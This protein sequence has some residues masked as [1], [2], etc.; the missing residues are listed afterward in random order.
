VRTIEEMLHDLVVEPHRTECLEFIKTYKGLFDTSKGSAIKHQA[1]PGGYRDH[2][3]EVMRICLV[4]YQA[5]NGSVRTPPFTLSHALVGCFL[6]D[7]EKLWKHAIDPEH[8]QDIDKNDLL[9]GHFTMDADL[10]NS[11]KYAHGEGDDYHPTKLV[12][13]PLAAFVHHCDN[14]SARIWPGEPAG[15]TDDDRA[16]AEYEFIV[17]RYYPDEIDGRIAKRML[18]LENLLNLET[19]VPEELDE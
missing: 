2:I 6:H 17:K 13:S 15:L 9:D 8:R 18:E 3:R 10:W 12:Q 1:W 11:V 19:L 4:T 7:V 16:S 14:T 5:L